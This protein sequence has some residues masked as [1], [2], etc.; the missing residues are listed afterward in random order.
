MGYKTCASIIIDFISPQKSQDEGRSYLRAT[1]IYHYSTLLEEGYLIIELLNMKR[2]LD[3]LPL[4]QYSHDDHGC[5]SS[6]SI[7]AFQLSFHSKLH[8]WMRYMNHD[9]SSNVKNQ[10]SLVDGYFCEHNKHLSQ[11]FC[12]RFYNACKSCFRRANFFILDRA[13]FQFVIKDTEETS[14]I[15]CI[16]CS[17]LHSYTLVR[18]RY[19]DGRSR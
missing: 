7:S 5:I 18:L 9:E 6:L 11:T 15:S 14:T 17:F 16:Y 1:C 10:S 2:L 3:L 8:I 4:I 19:D 13:P 12:P